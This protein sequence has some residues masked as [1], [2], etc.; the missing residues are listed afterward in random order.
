MLDTSYLRIDGTNAM[1]ADLN[2][3]GNDLVNADQIIGSGAVTI[4]DS[5]SASVVTVDSTATHISGITEFTGSDLTRKMK[6]D[7]NG[8][9]P[10]VLFNSNYKSFLDPFQFG[11]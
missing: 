9:G 11:G 1:L 6:I 7:C 8:G 5:T 4:K 10:M 3:N 2:I